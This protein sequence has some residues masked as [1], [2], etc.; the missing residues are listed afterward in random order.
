M[1]AIRMVPR[2]LQPSVSRHL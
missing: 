2:R 1:F